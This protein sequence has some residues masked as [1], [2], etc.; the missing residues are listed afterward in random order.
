MD[1]CLVLLQRASLA[2]AAGSGLGLNPRPKP[3]ITAAL[4]PS[5]WLEGDWERPDDAKAVHRKLSPNCPLVLGMECGNMP[6]SQKVT[7]P[8]LKRF[9]FIVVSIFEQ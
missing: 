6:R 7:C 3:C 9:I 2:L 4:P 8:D 5:P 1:E